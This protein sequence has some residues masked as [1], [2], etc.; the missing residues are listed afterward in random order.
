VD[1][2]NKAVQVLR[3]D[4]LVLLIEIV[5]IAIEYFDEEFDGNG[6]VHAGVRYAK[7]TLEAFENAFAVSV[8]L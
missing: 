4:G 8:E 2:F 1:K 7:R 5:Y 3:R 6:G